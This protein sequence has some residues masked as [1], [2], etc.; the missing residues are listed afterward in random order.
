MSF[1][2]RI[3]LV[4]AAA[5]AVAVI[6][7]SALTYLLASHQ[8]RK[9]VD[10][11]LRSRSVGLRVL[12]RDSPGALLERNQHFFSAPLLTLQNSPFANL[13]P[14]P[15]QVRGYQQLVDSAG[16]VLFRSS[17]NVTLP[18][19]AATLRLAAK[20]GRP[21]YRDAHTGDIHLRILAEPARSGYALELAQPLTN[22]DRLLG[23]LRIILVLL[24]AGGIALAALLGRL[25]AG[26]AVAP[27]KRLT[28]GTE[29]VTRTQ[30]LSLRIQPAG[31]DEIGRLAV[32]F[33][34]MLDALQSS[35]S[36]LDASVHAQRQLIADASHELRTPVTSLRTNIEILKQEPNMAVDERQRMLEDVVE[37][38]EELTLLMNDLI[39]LGRGEQPRGGSEDVRLDLVVEEAVERARRHSPETPFCVEI[40][41]VVLTGEPVRL[42]RAINNLIDNAVNYSPSTQSVEIALHGQELTVRDH[43]P[44]ISAADLPHVFDRFYRGA[45]AR[46]RPGSGLGLAIVRQVA[47]QHGGNVSAQLAPGGGTL[48]CLHL[49]G[50]E[51]V[52]PLSSLDAALHAAG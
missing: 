17:P 10:E 14:H 8:L 20:G 32:S 39:E 29:H 37:Q 1:R 2:R 9:Q 45:E 41:E 46:G 4:S 43:G 31:E 6:L 28:Q 50:V 12:A 35:M 21:F 18:V 13:S 40:D 16:K 19:T 36:A 30:D 5:V 26:A 25:V 33:N 47:E 24:D 38:I 22:V 34:A 15:D 44:G 7:A 23:R 42:E 11:Q 3:T 48:M 49:P 51:P 52:T 27:V